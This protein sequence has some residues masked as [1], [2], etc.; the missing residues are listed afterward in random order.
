MGETTEYD[1]K[2]PRTLTIGFSDGSK[3]DLRSFIFIGTNS[4][5]HELR[6]QILGTA[7]TN[8]SPDLAAKLAS[9]AIVLATELLEKIANDY[10]DPSQVKAKIAAEVIDI[11]FNND[12]TLEPGEKE[13]TYQKDKDGGIIRTV[14][15]GADPISNLNIDVNDMRN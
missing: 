14:K 10:N 1:D 3:E 2:E 11:L 4:T 9:R 7:K 6:S 15:N 5:G 13:V 8:C 12:R